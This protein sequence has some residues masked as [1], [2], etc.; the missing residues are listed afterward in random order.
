MGY[1]VRPDERAVKSYYDARPHITH[2]SNASQVFKET[3][4]NPLFDPSKIKLP[5]E[6]RDSAANPRSRGIIFAEDVTGSM[7]VYLMDLIKNQF[8]KLIKETYNISSYD[9]HIM[10]MGVGDVYCDSAPLQVT[11]FETDLKMLEQLQSIYLER[12]GGGNCFE[13]YILPWY[14]AGKHISMDCFEKRG[15]KGF[16]FTFG[17]E[18]PTPA[19]SSAEIKRVFGSNDT[20][21]KPSISKYDCLKMA[22]EKFHC[23]HIILDGYNYSMNVKKLWKDL[24]GGHACLLSDHKYLSELVTTILKMYEGKTK[25][26]AISELTSVE[27]KRVVEEALK[28][29]EEQVEDISVAP[30]EN[31]DIEEF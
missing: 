11:Q 24:M 26:E 18:E 21:K 27:A 15:E 17:D 8:P 14:F 31:A 7:D 16:L 6:A 10:F 12:G 13:S 25:T 3:D 9:P 5:R 28:D 20:L 23:Y 2:A 22:S 4:M 29:H 19:L 30:A 1:S